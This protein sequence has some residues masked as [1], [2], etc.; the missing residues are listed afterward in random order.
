MSAHRILSLLLVV[1]CTTSTTDKSDEDPTSTDGGSDGSDGGDGADGADG[2]DG[3][4]TGE[5]DS[6]C[7]STEA[8]N[9]YEATHAKGVD[10][11]AET[12]F[13]Q[14]SLARLDI[15]I[16]PEDRET[17]LANLDELYGGSSG[18]GGGG[19]GGGPGDEEFAEEDPVYVPVHV[20]FGDQN[21]PMVGMRH[22]GNSSLSFSVR[23]GIEKLPFRLNFDY[24]EDDVPEVDNQRFHGYKEL[25]F[26]SGYSDPSLIRDKLTSELFQEAGVP[27]ADG[28]FMAVYVDAGDGPVYWGVYNVFEDPAGELL[29][30]WF[31]GDQGNAYK[32]EGDGA[33]FETF[34]ESAWEKKTNEEEA[35][36]SDAQAFVAALNADRSDAAA[37]RTNLEATLDVDGYLRYLAMNN[38]VGNWDAYGQMTH[39]FYMYGDPENGGRLSWI[40]WDFNE[41]LLPE[42]RQ[43][44]VSVAMTEVSD[45][46]PLI[47]YLADDPVYIARYREHIEDLMATV[48]TEDHIRTKAEA[49]HAYVADA[50]AA[51]AA[52][53]THL[54]NISEFEDSL[55]DRTGI[56]TRVTDAT[57]EANAWLA[58]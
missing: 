8:S 35:D 58:D 1:G 19:G 9:W 48:F 33:R 4:D 55:Y 54:R 16:C 22:K 57:E 27:A 28:G 14:P 39:N 18:G 40:P 47:R 12:V 21:W 20:Q 32:P 52:P 10:G 15:I 26:S 43:A 13:G 45:E 37:W 5:A 49:A 51:E 56:M 24:Y 3:G 29:D 6:L 2:A 25:K 23:D 50:V 38:L 31:G 53:Y 44:P 7:S 11:D 34:D 36:W 30:H 42:S 46:W 41:T 17:M